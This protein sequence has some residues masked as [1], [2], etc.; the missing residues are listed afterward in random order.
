M[1]LRPMNDTEP[2]VQQLI[3]GLYR[4]TDIGSQDLAGTGFCVCSQP[5]ANN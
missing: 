5:R 2:R 3:H 4:E 1:V